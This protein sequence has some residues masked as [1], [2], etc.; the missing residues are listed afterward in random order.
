VMSV[1]LAGH[2][3][4]ASELAWA[5]QLLAHNPKAQHRLVE[6]IDAD[7][8]CDFL[9]ATV[10]EVLRRRPVFLF[11]I[12]RAVKEPVEIG[13]WTHA[14]PAHLLACIYLIH[15]HPS[16]PDAHAFRP[17]RFLGGPGDLPLWIPWGGGRKICPGRRLATLEMRT[18]LRTALAEATVLPCASRIERAR[19]RSVIVTPHDGGRVILRRRR[20]R[21]SRPHPVALAADPAAGEV[22]CYAAR[23]PTY[24]APRSA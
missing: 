23:T 19:W 18:V 24:A 22:S 17:E 10:H 1:I 13:G 4:T 21:V 3:T 5:F 2:E 11:A 12:P 15:H 8:D 9:D 14:P 6:E 20:P 16:I 7:A